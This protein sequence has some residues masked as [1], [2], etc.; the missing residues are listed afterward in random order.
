MHAQQA[1]EKLTGTVAEAAEVLKI[2]LNPAYEAAN[3]G[4]IPTMRIGRRLVVK[5]VPFMRMV[6]GEVA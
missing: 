1:G 2:G 4:D 6:R 5:W 3:R